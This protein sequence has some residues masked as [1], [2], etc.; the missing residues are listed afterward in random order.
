MSG[1]TMDVIA[2]TAFGLDARSLD[3]PENEFLKNAKEF[4]SFTN[5]RNPKRMTALILTGK[6]K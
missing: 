2:G 6:H 5:Q 4:F 3:D 1:Y